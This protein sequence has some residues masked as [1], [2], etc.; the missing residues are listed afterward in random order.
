[1]VYTNLA[2]LIR[3]ESV[4][5]LLHLCGNTEAEVGNTASDYDYWRAV[6]RAIPLLQGHSFPSALATFLKSELN[7]EMSIDCP[8]PSTLW[9]QGAGALI[10]RSKIKTHFDFSYPE[11]TDI[12]HFSCHNNRQASYVDTS[13]WKNSTAVDWNA[14]ERELN[15]RWEICAQHTEVV[16]L[17][18]S[19]SVQNKIP[20]LYHVNLALSQKSDEE[21]ILAVQ[22]LRFLCITCKRDQ[23]ALILDMD[24]CTASTVVTLLEQLE[25][26]V[27][28]PT[29]VL[30]VSSLDTLNTI[31]PFLWRASETNIRIGVC[32]S[33]LT[34]A[35]S[36]SGIATSYP[37]GRLIVYAQKGDHLC[38]FSVFSHKN[39]AVCP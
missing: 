9:Q 12:V 32:E 1:M 21:G 38:F 20:S 3:N 28:L 16:F 37:I 29:T 5:N 39:E 24:G 26:T 6:C 17:S 23:K 22:L 14:M 36:L 11:Q 19:G 2:E 33:K 8:D 18:L 7:L 13:T 4:T 25:S 34:S 30:S 27:G 31:L 35:F 10:R 15:A